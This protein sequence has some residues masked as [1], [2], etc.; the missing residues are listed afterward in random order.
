MNTKV[1]Q[2]EDQ[3]DAQGAAADEA[4]Q[5]DDAF[6][7]EI[8]DDVPEEAKPRT[9]EAVKPEDIADDD[10]LESYSESVQ[11]RIKKLTFEAKEAARQREAAARER[12]EA[13]NYARS[14]LQQNQ[15]LQDTVSKGRTYVVEQMKGRV[16]VELERAK[17]DYKAAYETGDS[18]KMVDAQSRLVD[19]Q[20]QLSQLKSWRPPTAQPQVP[21][22]PQAPQQQSQPKPTLSERQQKWLSNN[23]WYGENSEMTGFALGVHERLVRNGVDPD[24][25]TYYTEIDNAMRKRFADEFSDGESKEVAAPPKKSANVVAPAARS[26]PTSRKIRL[27]STQV[28]LAKRLG[29]S[30][31]QYAAQLMKE[32]K[33]G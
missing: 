7:I 18:D 28:A 29:I 9:E 1:Q 25:E 3:V 31:E 33:D 32:A 23:S 21:T 26:A 13:I 17:A 8:V 2:A 22:Q 10:D 15:E 14:I 6:E 5:T 12:E 24:S 19:L 30:P 27:T 11:K 4:T 16:E 20:G